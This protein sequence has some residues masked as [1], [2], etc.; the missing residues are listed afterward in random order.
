MNKF[1]KLYEALVIKPMKGATPEDKGILSRIIRKSKNKLKAGDDVF[2][3]A[4]GNLMVIIKDPSPQSLK[5]LIMRLTKEGLEHKKDFGITRE[6]PVTITIYKNAISKMNDNIIDVLSTH[7]DKA[8][9]EP[10]TD[11]P[12][13]KVPVSLIPLKPKK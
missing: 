7:A 12:K 8:K 6:H 10:Q 9:W 1:D 13:K 11:E 5:A 2:Y 3:D 4:N